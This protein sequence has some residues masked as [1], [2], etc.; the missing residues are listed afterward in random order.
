MEKFEVI[1]EIYKVLLDL[2]IRMEI[3]EVTMR[4]ALKALR[5]TDCESAELMSLYSN[6]EAEY[7]RCKAEYER[8]I[9][10]AKKDKGFLDF[11]KYAVDVPKELQ[12]LVAALRSDAGIAIGF[13][14]GNE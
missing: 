7:Q 12:H 10:E 8:L 3:A 2:R 4:D 1:P 13:E 11:L 9:E 6:T 14:I 5:S